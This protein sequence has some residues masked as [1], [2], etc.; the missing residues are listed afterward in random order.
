MLEY[1]K[2]LSRH[3]SLMELDISVAAC[4]NGN[5]LGDPESVRLF[6]VEYIKGMEFEVV[7][8]VDIDSIANEYPEMIDKYVYVG[9]SRANLY[10]AVTVQNEFPRALSYLEPMFSKQGTWL[11]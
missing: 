1:A 11:V 5:V 9:L 4:A 3:E 8:F 10:L 7:F 6:A 2:E